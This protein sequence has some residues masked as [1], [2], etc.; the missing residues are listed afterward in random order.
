[1]K[2]MFRKCEMLEYDFLCLGESFICN[3]FDH[4]SATTEAWQGAEWQ[5]FAFIARATR[6]TVGGAHEKSK[7]SL[8]ST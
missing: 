6:H 2:P 7:A 3:T 1:M 5:K 4:L 8:S